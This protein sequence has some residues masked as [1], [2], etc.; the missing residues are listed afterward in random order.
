MR[1][2]ARWGWAVWLV[3]G[4]M[5]CAQSD[6]LRVDRG[7][8]AL[9]DK[10]FVPVETP[11]HLKAW[12]KPAGAGS[13]R[14][15]AEVLHVYLEGDGAAWWAQRIPPAD[16]T[17]RDSVA[18]SLAQSDPH[19]QVAYLGRPCQ[20]LSEA[21]RHDCPMSW[22]TSDRWGESA[23]S[24][25]T[26]ALDAIRQASGARELVLVGH[27][28]G[29]TLA[30]LVASRRQDVCCVV[31]IAAP[32]DVQAWAQAHALTPLTGSLNPADLPVPTGR[33]E[34]R[35]LQ[36]EADRVVPASA[37]GRYGARLR[38]DQWMTIPEQGHS[39]G[40]VQ[41]WRQAQNPDAP[42]HRWL[43]GCMNRA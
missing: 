22:W 38:P 28:G 32:L 27:S 35:H 18:L 30:L 14:E 41:R 37:L 24:L 8:A 12:R 7:L 15:P 9:L 23:V 33:F 40:W 5:G 29:G 34:E 1:V 19:A 4:L 16:P 17:P 21:A 13:R 39:R 20:F 10:G 31:T 11:T 42:L 36:G 26:Q 43:Q 2:H 3:L 25:T 6:L